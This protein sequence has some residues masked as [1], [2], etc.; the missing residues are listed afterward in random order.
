M[1]EA[2]VDAVAVVSFFRGVTRL[3][4]PEESVT[5]I[6][7]FSSSASSSRSVPQ[8]GSENS[9]QTGSSSGGFKRASFALR[10]LASTLAVYDAMF[11]FL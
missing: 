8:Y 1:V 2:V 7:L 6:T 5:K 4:F 11:C 9:D 3:I 10:I